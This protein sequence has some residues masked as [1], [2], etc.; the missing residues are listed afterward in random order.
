MK[1]FIFAFIL[2]ALLLTANAAPFQLNK[3]ATT[4]FGPCNT[5]D[6]VDLL[7]VDIGTDPPVSGKDETFYVSGEMTKLD[8]APFTILMINYYDTEGNSF[9]ASFRDFGKTIKAGIQFLKVI[10]DPAPNLP[11]KYEIRV[12]V[13]SCTDTANCGALHVF[14]CASANFGG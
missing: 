9:N 7:N 12:T 11:D 3:R 13:E 14:A 6:P 10:T 8:I 1:N 2:F 5:T 4:T